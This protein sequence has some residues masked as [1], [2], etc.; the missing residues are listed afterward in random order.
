[1]WWARR[2]EID[3]APRR[4]LRE[5]KSPTS[6]RIHPL[7]AFLY[8]PWPFFLFYPA[9][10]YFFPRSYYIDLSHL[11]GRYRDGALEGFFP[12]GE[13]SEA[14][15]SSG[16]SAEAQAKRRLVVL[17]EGGQFYYD[18]DG[19]SSWDE[20]ETCPLPKEAMPVEEAQCALLACGEV[21]ELYFIR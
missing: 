9:I 6:T 12:E 16:S 20:T 3:P 14:S 5:V 8:V 13:F 2:F 4:A 18:H 17:A 7:H 21:S 1:M 10:D 15:S 19:S 11:F